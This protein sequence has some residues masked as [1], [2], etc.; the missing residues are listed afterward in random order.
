MNN[1][2][3]D[4][5]HPSSSELAKATFIAAGVAALLLITVI[6]PAEYDIDPLGTGAMLGLTVL[7][8]DRDPYDHEVVI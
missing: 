1:N 5:I 6:L 2:P 3:I 4:Q 8:S 7:A